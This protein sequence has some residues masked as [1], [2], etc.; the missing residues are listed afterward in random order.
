MKKFVKFAAGAAALAGAVCGVLY[1]LQKVLGV[2]IF[3]KDTDDIDDFDDDFDD[4]DGFDDDSDDDSE[5]REY[6]TLDLE[7]ESDN[8][9]EPAQAEEE[10]TGAAEA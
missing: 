6:V 2:D 4:I 7:K 8:K 3:K 1:F 9:E 5:E 10:T